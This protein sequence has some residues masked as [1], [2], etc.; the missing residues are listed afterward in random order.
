MRLGGWEAGRQKGYEAGIRG[1]RTDVKSQKEEFTTEHREKK[2]N[3]CR[4][5]RFLISYYY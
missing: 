1:Q 5:N 3:F 2:Y 4:I